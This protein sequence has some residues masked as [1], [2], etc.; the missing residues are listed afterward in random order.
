MKLFVVF[1][2]IANAPKKSY[3]FPLYETAI[4]VLEI[5]KG[6]HIAFGYNYMISRLQ[7]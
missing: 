3:M 4:H 6:N 5:Q 2:N 7:L 1:R